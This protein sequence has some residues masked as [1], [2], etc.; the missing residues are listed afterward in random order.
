MN[1]KKEGNTYRHITY[2]RIGSARHTGWL[3]IY[4]HKDLQRQQLHE[5]HLRF[6]ITGSCRDEGLIPSGLLTSRR[7]L[8]KHSIK[9]YFIGINIHF[10]TA[11]DLYDKS[12]VRPADNGRAAIASPWGC[13]VTMPAILR[14][15]RIIVIFK[16]KHFCFKYLTSIHIITNESVIVD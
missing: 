16:H 15:I 4:S 12:F 5:E 1:L 6:R 14:K 10:C 9:F 8:T 7:D 11:A 13:Q 3:R 2:K